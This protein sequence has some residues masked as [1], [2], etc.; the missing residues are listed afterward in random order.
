MFK[1]NDL[2]RV[3][4]KQDGEFTFKLWKDD[5][6]VVDHVNRFG[7]VFL[8][9]KRGSYS[10]RCFELAKEEER[11]VSI[12]GLA[13]K[14]VT[15]VRPADNGDRSYSHGDKLEILAVNEDTRQIEYRYV[16]R[17]WMA[18]KV[19]TMDFDNWSNGWKVL[20]E[21]KPKLESLSLAELIKVANEGYKAIELLESKYKLDTE[22]KCDGEEWKPSVAVSAP[23][24]GRQY[25]I[26]EAKRVSIDGHNITVTNKEVKVG[27]QTF[28]KQRLRDW[29]ES[30]YENGNDAAGELTTSVHYVRARGYSATHEAAKELLKFLKAN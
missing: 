4:E 6:H 14:I 20:G 9:G 5:L 26:A 13:D 10:P 23:C 21:A 17:P 12:H 16:E 22:W 25:R 3:L 2:V 8:I 30:I 7:T 28:D 15:R 11:G 24:T 1:K 27:C 18:D 19:H 29:L